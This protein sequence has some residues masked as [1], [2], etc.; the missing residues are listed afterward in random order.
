MGGKQPCWYYFHLI[1]VVFCWCT[2]YHSEASNWLA[3]LFVYLTSKLMVRLHFNG[4]VLLGIT[5]APSIPCHK[6]VEDVVRAEK[7]NF[8]PA[9]LVPNI[10]A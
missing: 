9:F 7:G 8:T 3:V 1:Y 6:P 4:K 10:W 2:V 5:L